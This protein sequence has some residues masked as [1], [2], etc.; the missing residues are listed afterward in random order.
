MSADET[1]VGYS[2]LRD[3]KPLEQSAECDQLLPLVPDSTRFGRDYLRAGFI[4]E[5]VQS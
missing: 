5:S 2:D 3:L 4:V 1:Q